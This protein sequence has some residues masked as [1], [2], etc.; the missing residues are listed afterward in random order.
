[1]T[2]EICDLIYREIALRFDSEPEN[3]DGLEFSDNLAEIIEKLIILHIR[4]WKMED[5]VSEAK[6]DKSVADLKKKIDFLFKIKRPKLL[7]ALNL[8]IDNYVYNSKPFREENVKFYN[9]KLQ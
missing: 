6:D 8:L 4:I 3:I 1:M 7:C 9:C 5:S 2:T